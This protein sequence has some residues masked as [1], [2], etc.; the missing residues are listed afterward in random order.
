MRSSFAADG[1]M[2]ESVTTTQLISRRLSA[3]RCA[4]F[5][6][7]AIHLLLRNPLRAHVR[8][9]RLTRALTDT[10]V[11]ADVAVR[12]V[13][14]PRGNVTQTPVLALAWPFAVMAVPPRGALCGERNRNNGL[15]AYKDK[16]K[17]QTLW[18]SPPRG[19]RQPFHQRGSRQLCWR[20]AHAGVQERNSRCEGPPVQQ[21][22]N[23]RK[24]LKVISWQK[25]NNAVLLR[26]VQNLSAGDRA[27]K[28]PT[29]QKKNSQKKWPE[30]RGER[31]C[32]SMSCCLQMSHWETHW[33]ELLCTQGQGARRPV[34][35][36]TQ[37]PG[38]KS[39]A[40][41]KSRTKQDLGQASEDEG[42]HGMRPGK[43]TCASKLLPPAGCSPRWGFSSGQPSAVPRAGGAMALHRHR[44][45]SRHWHRAFRTQH[46]LGQQPAKVREAEEELTQLAGGTV[47]AGGTDARP[48]DRVAL[49][50]GSGTLADLPTALTEGPWPAGCQERG[51]QGDSDALSGSYPTPLCKTLL[52]LSILSQDLGSLL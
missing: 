19:L 25:S 40:T 43:T 7:T 35:G 26:T 31:C 39:W 46:S 3:R 17:V 41:T 33:S 44:R 50:G 16:N 9:P 5:A 22:P 27:D 4:G 12:A 6:P 38:C 30:C 34:P 20:W 24:H 14:H 45:C 29:N 1:S 47:E 15:S 51:H 8:P 36:Q 21:E 10:A 48:G 49:L 28:C 18:K 11:S 42:D 13:A 32:V 52:S 2:Q 37:L 23:L